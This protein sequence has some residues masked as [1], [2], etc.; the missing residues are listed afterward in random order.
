MDE[1]TMN[2][3]AEDLCP[4]CA[5]RMEDCVCCPECGHE[6]ALDAGEAYCPVCSPVKKS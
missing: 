1:K 5:N 6:C 4:V 3:P 2:V